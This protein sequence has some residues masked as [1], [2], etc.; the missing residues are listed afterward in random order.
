MWVSTTT[1]TIDGE[2]IQIRMSVDRATVSPAAKE[3]PVG[4]GILQSE[5]TDVEPDH[6]HAGG[7]NS[8]WINFS[9]AQEKYVVGGVKRRG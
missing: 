3:T 7:S 5:N 4:K 9:D 8:A 2:E 1:L 6:P